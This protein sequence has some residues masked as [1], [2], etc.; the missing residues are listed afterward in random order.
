VPTALLTGATGFVGG[1]VAQV[2][3]SQG[4]RVRALARR[5]LRRDGSAL[6]DLPV[7]PILGDLS[8]SSDLR[9][10]LEG[11]DAVVHVAGLVKA[12]T[13]EDY[14]E[15]NARGTERLLAAALAV[16]PSARFVLVSTQAAAGPARGGRPVLE[17]DPARP[18]SWY[19]LSKREGESAVE[20]L[21]KGEWV[22]LRPG[23][24]YG[25]GDRGVFTFF[26]MAASGW[27]LL[28]AA[29]SRVQLLSAEEAALAIARAAV[30]PGIS[31]RIGYLCNPEPI[32]IR[33]L[34]ETIA[35]LPRRRPRLLAV[36]APF[37]RLAGALETVRET[38]TR[39]SR[40][41]NADK[42]RELLAGDWLCDPGPMRKSLDLPDPEP[43]EQ[44]LKR[45]WDWYVSRGWINANA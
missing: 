35:T 5:P 14:R 43:L 21:W 32:Q 45:T 42:A 41:F 22:I 8:G 38:L 3:A 4:W 12:R 34:V 18:V 7:E 26:Q 10:A 20:R 27:L 31:S 39:R 24:V 40:P 23:V 37:V 19:G 2:L 28:P 9:G 16:A 44:G 33:R 6:S 29:E 1:H 30:R 11:C 36:P 25:P 17:G 15:V 13:L